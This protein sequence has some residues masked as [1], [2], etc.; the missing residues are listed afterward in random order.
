MLKFNKI[1]ATI[2]AL[3]LGIGEAVMNWGNWQ[4]APL[5]LVDYMIVAAL[6]FGVL[7]KTP[8]SAASRLKCAWVFAFAIMY[9]AFFISI[10]GAAQGFY[11]T[12][13]DL[14]FIIGAL[15]GLAVLGFA[16]SVLTEKAIGKKQG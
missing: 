10:D 4:Y 13:K 7:A 6:L 2:Y 11:E 5:W 15:M 14:L 12:P 3:G 1:L 9:M 8:A 16:L